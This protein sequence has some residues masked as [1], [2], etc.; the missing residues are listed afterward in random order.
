MF[1][2]SLTAAKAVALI[3]ALL[4]WDAL[5]APPLPFVPRCQ[6]RARACTP[7]LRPAAAAAASS[8]CPL[9]S[10]VLRK[11]PLCPPR[12]AVAPPALAAPSC[13]PGMLT[14]PAPTFVPD[15]GF[16]YLVAFRAR[17]RA[18]A[19]E[20]FG[21]FPSLSSL[22]GCPLFQPNRAWLVEQCPG[23]FHMVT[24]PS[25]PGTLPTAIAIASMMGPWAI[26]MA[27][28][29]GGP[30]RL[31]LPPQASLI[32]PAVR[33]VRFDD[34]PDG[35]P[36]DQRRDQPRGWGRPPLW[37]SHPPHDTAAEAEAA[38]PPPPPSTKCATCRPAGAPPPLL[39]LPFGR[40]Q[41]AT[42]STPS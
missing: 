34:R 23:L 24:D 37:A 29:Q 27:L 30:S 18:V 35:A 36:H 17:H 42:S 2:P 40:A 16:C 3:D 1:C 10:V 15:S 32:P 25:S 9:D 26:G 6:R 21:P 38:T 5:L 8:P 11:S 13:R 22:F 12:A 28:P 31:P 4:F 39:T 19:A 14:P 33:N 20:A 7:A 41:S